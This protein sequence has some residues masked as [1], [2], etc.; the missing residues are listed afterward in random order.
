M[1]MNNFKQ[2]LKMG[3]FSGLA[4]YLLYVI[5]VVAVGMM[6][7]W[8]SFWA[9]NE[10]TMALTLVPN[11]V[12][13]WEIVNVVGLILA[14]LVPVFL[15]RYEKV[16]YAFSYIVISLL[17]FVWLFG[18]TLGAYYMIG[19]MKNTMLFCPFSTFDAF[20]YLIFVFLLGSA[21]GTM[22]SFAINFMRNKD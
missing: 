11:G 20:Y 10:E 22:A 3:V 16:K 14:S 15:M 7:K 17:A 2:S 19:D 1:E 4:T 13:S 6:T 8:Q 9:L 5:F 12:I 18:A 21:I